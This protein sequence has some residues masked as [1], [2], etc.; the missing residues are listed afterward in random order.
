MASLEQHGTVVVWLLIETRDNEAD[1]TDYGQAVGGRVRLFRSGHVPLTGGGYDAN[2]TGDESPRAS[3]RKRGGGDSALL[4]LRTLCLGFCPGEVSRF[5]VGGDTGQMLHGSRHAGPSAS[6]P[7][8]RVFEPEGA[9]PLGAGA[10]M[11][12]SLAFCPVPGLHAYMAA[13][14]SDGSL[15]LYQI[16]D[17]RPLRTWQGFTTAAL[18]Q[19]QWSPVRPCVLW[20][21]DADATLHV[22]DLL[23]DE[24]EPVVSTPLRKN[25]PRRPPPLGRSDG[26]AARL[27][28]AL[29][30]RPHA[31]ESEA[32]SMLAVTCSPAADESCLDVHLLTERLSRPVEGEA[33]QLQRFLEA[34]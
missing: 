2:A 10:C 7:T 34:L 17:P 25:A 8:P 20:T 6:K 23:D 30:T 15:S 29:G 12:H 11:V 4:P 33:E 28:I 9:A 5:V 3:P 16:D 32:P 31:R 1:A 13:A 26:A 19:V 18:L 24:S 22:F 27:R 21:I 14:R